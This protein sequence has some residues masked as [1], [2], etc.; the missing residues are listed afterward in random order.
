MESHEFVSINHLFFKELNHVYDRKQSV[1]TNLMT[2]ELVI[3]LTEVLCDLKT[4]VISRANRVITVV[5][6]ETAPVAAAPSQELRDSLIDMYSGKHH[7]NWHSTGK[8]CFILVVEL[9]LYNVLKVKITSTNGDN[10]LQTS[11]QH[12][13]CNNCI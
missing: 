4:G 6:R 3:S 5:S 2:S 1:P 10:M 11:E 8:R 13:S 9:E 7:D 12:N